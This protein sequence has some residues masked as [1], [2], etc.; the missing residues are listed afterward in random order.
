MKK[1]YFISLFALTS[2]YEAEHNCADFRT[3]TFRFNFEVKGVKKTGTF[4]R[5]ENLEIET[6]DGKTDSASIRWVN[7]CEY[8]V[9]TLHPKNMAEREAITMKILT[10]SKNSYTF[11]YGVVNKDERRRGTAIKIK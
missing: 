2:C 10:T 3:G 6:Y 1:Y 11:E 4:V 7:D 5:T 8:I 9:Q